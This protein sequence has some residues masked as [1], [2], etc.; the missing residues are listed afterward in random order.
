MRELKAWS[1]ELEF[2]ARLARVEPTADD[3]ERARALA[4]GPVDWPRV[5]R[6]AEHHGLAP[7]LHANVSRIDVPSLPRDVRTRLR[8]ARLSFVSA[9]LARY[10]AWLRVCRAFDERGIPVLTLK[11]FPVVLATY[12][13]LGLRPVGDLDLLVHQR[14]VPAAIA[15]LQELGYDLWRDW[16]L[17][18]RHVGLD[19][20]L[21]H[22]AEVGL[23]SPRGI[24]VDLHWRANDGDKA[25][26]TDAL[27]VA[28][29]RIRIDGQ[30]VLVPSPDLAMVLLLLH[31]QK[32]AWARLRWLVDVA[33]GMEK[34]SQA[35]FRKMADRLAALGMLSALANALWLIE[36][37][38][39]RLPVHCRSFPPQGDAIR[40][41]MLR[42]YVGVID[43]DL[44]WN[45]I[46]DKWR[47][48]RMLRDRFGRIPSLPAAVA[49]AAQPNVFDWAVVPLP[50]GLRAGYSAVRAVR[51]IRAALA[52]RSRVVEAPPAGPAAD[53]EREPRSPGWSTHAATPLTFVT[54]IYGF[55]PSTHLGGRGRNIAHYLPSL[56]NI[57]NLG[58]PIVVYCPAMDA[59]AIED[60][61]AP[62]FRDLRVIPFELSEFEHFDTVL[63]FKKSY[64]NDLRIN[65][66]NE[67]LCFLKAYWVRH[68][69]EQNFF[70]HDTYFWIDAGVTHHGVFP[71][72]VGGVELLVTHPPSRYHPANR[73]NIFTPQLGAAL[74]RA[75]PRGRLFF[76]ALP[77]IGQGGRREEYERL[78]AQAYDR[79]R[80]QVH[81]ADHLVGGLFGGHR[82]D[83]TAFHRRYAALLKRY[84]DAR[85]YTLEEQVFSG[86]YAAEPELFA[87][88]RFGTW[89]FYAPGERTSRLS[90]E[91]DSFYKIFARLLHRAP[92]AEAAH[93][94]SSDELAVR[95]RARAQRG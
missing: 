86:L 5:L 36:S 7:L 6:L 16:Q 79:P 21:R 50:P 35:D 58:A 14:N 24:E 88:H 19:Y 61:I 54:A 83:F 13:E 40:P 65:D 87:L 55:G 2:V 90:A 46:H 64:V 29:D 17:A 84:L 42:H 31:G 22:T 72:R 30:D 9:D 48:V 71:E 52:R 27:I 70:G 1:A 38:W 18:L 28:A 34:L 78:V 59:P 67:T 44:A 45:L 75:V 69:I 15:L 73:A 3:V 47:P 74:A 94:A 76:C 8:Y 66:R 68:A 89:W 95:P 80:D 60:A 82:D 23:S 57:G 43:H 56:I 39:G 85:V 93:L 37:L 63:E 49:S 26:S 12:G 41:R 62:Y 11:G 77:F 91:G 4:A 32:S 20:V 25:P 51:V 10:E 33:E 53:P 81:I 92:Q